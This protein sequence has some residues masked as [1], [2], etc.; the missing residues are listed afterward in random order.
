M[1]HVLIATPT[2]GGVV[3]A[4]Y[5]TTL[6]KAVK[7]VKEAG[8][9]VDLVTI[10][11]SYVTKARNYFAH[12]LLHQPHVTHLVMIDSDMSVEGDVV[13]R[14][15][16]CGRPVVA[17][18][19]PQRR[20]DMGAF[21]RAARDPEL[22]PADLAALAMEYNIQPEPE[23]GTR[24]VRVSDGMCR[25]RQVAL[26]C[27]AIRRDAFES[28]IAAGMV[29]QRPDYLLQKSGLEGPFHGFFDEITLEDGTRLSED[30]SFCKRWLGVPGNELWAVVDE[31]VG[32][33]G[34]MVYGAPYL[35]RLLQGKS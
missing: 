27:A 22:A 11:G 35:Q 16:G 12:L 13:T 25:V 17:A 5:A 9:G 8:W 26:G 28:L 32:H 6:V 19:Y 3:K 30:Y 18:A 10:D 33:V 24:Q 23:A 1:M 2:A 21:A 15:V 31:P 34:D 29:R 4:A 14:L 7:A 20:M